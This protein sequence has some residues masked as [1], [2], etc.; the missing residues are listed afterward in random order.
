HAHCPVI[1]IP[2]PALELAARQWIAAPGVAAPAIDPAA[3]PSVLRAGGHGW[4]GWRRRPG[5]RR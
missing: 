1:A 2:P 4:T 5:R 3:L